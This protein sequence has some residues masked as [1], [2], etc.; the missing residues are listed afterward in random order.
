MVIST[1]INSPTM[2]QERVQLALPALSIS[3]I[4]GWC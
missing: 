2:S 4:K 3:M 1:P